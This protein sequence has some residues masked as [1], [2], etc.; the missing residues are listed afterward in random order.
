VVDEI[1]S[2]SKCAKCKETEQKERKQ[3]ESDRF[4]T[5]KKLFDV[6]LKKNHILL[7]DSVYLNEDLLT[8]T[9]KSYYDD[10]YRFKD[11][12]GSK[13]ADRHK[14][15]AYTIKW[16]S[17][18]KPIQIKPGFSAN[19]H[20][21]LVNS[22]FAIFVGFIFLDPIISENIPTPFLEHLIYSTLYRDISGKQLAGTIYLIEEF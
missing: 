22:S 12:S 4:Q 11:Y 15:V 14:Q 7:T 16:I 6:F 9:V 21:L 20:S 5:I 10:I 1:N 2:C 3:K 17:K 18:I 13:H 19:K 8:L